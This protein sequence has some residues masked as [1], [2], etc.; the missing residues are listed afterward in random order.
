MRITEEFYRR[1]LPH[2]EKPGASY[3]ITF[4]LEGSIPFAALDKIKKAYKTDISEYDK[5]SDLYLR[6]KLKYVRRKKFMVDY[7][8]LL[9]GIC[10]G[11]MYLAKPE[12]REI[13]EEQIHRF[14][15]KLYDLESYS[16]MSNHVHILFDSYLESKDLQIKPDAFTGCLSVAKIMK[17]IKGASARYCNKKLGRD[18]TFWAA[19]SFDMYIRNEEMYWNVKNYILNNPLKAGIVEEWSDFLGNYSR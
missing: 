17:R 14:D 10:C 16:I 18:G 3:F 5:I 9:D 6:N 19:E 8:L 4:R 1:K 7:D 11:P 12:I 13:V 2:I 15:G